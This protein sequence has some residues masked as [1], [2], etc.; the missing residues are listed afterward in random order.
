MT[1]SPTT[2]YLG[3]AGGEPRPPALLVDRVLKRGRLS[4]AFRALLLI[5]QI[6]VLYAL[7]LVALVLL[8]LGWF[9]ALFMGR[10]PEPFARYLRHFLGYGIRVLA[11]GMFLTD[12]YP[13]FQLEA[14]GYPIVVE[15]APPG[16][17]NRL[18]VLFRIFLLIPAAILVEVAFI[19]WT[20]A[21]FFIWLIVLILGRVPGAL[22]DATTALVR[23]LLRYDAYYLL[24]TPAYPW[25][26][27][28]D[29]VAAPAP[30]LTQPFPP[31]APMPPGPA[32]APGE[33]GPPEEPSPAETTLVSPA[34]PAPSAPVETAPVEPEPAAAPP[35]AVGAAAS[36]PEPAAAP[37]AAV[38]AAASEAT[39]AGGWEPPAPAPAA[40]RGLLALSSGARGLVTLF[41]VLGA[42]YFVGSGVFGAVSYSLNGPSE[43]ETLQDLT[44]AHDSLITKGQKFQQD[45][46]ACASAP[47]GQQLTCVQTADRD[48]V[49]AF[50]AFAGDVAAL[51]FPAS[52]RAEAREVERLGRQFAGAMRQLVAAPT[53]EEYTRLAA[54]TDQIG[55]SFDQ[56]YQAL[57]NSLAA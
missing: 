43:V 17:L 6:I 24:V 50:E 26:L 33:P 12:R 16:R 47:Q 10:L 4:V 18:A 7:G 54:G 28:G 53:P 11:Y 21:S 51:D 41:V 45:V 32:A 8:V 35:A 48:L 15:L 44:A 2:P 46:G 55:T 49:A 20:V 38:G 31:A 52:S 57:V 19:G 39:P 22:Y 25:G 42:L 34:E 56:R 36:E 14:E 5:P 29:R 3:T 27:F 40:P 37:P 9:A 30:A 13:P 1:D 23:Y